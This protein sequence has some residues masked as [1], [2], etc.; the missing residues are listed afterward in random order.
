ME[1]KAEELT[2]TAQQQRTLRGKLATMHGYLWRPCD[3]SDADQC[4][5][6]APPAV[7]HELAV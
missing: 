5:R 7:F 6:R 1:L 2:K 4:E 3:D